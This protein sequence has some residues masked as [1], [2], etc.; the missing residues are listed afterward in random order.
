[1]QRTLL[2][3]NAVGLQIALVSDNNDGEVVLVLDA[4]DLLLVR[5]DFLKGLARGDRVDQKEAF[6][7]AHVLLS[8]GR[9][10][11][12]ASRV[13]NVQQGDFIIDHALLAV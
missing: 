12:L 11:L 2:G 4:Q 1:M 3:D 10:F 9:V 7:R 13:Q 5:H 6:S 8:H